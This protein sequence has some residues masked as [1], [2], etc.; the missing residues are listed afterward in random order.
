MVKWLCTVCNI[1]IYDEDRGDPDKGIVPNTRLSELPDS[2]RCPVCGAAIDK[3]IQIHE[4]DNKQKATI[5]IPD[6]K[7]GKKGILIGVDNP[8]ASSESKQEYGKPLGLRGIGQGFSYI[9]NFKALLR[10]RLKTK[11]IAQHMEPVLSTEFFDHKISMP[12]IGAPMSGLSNVNNITEEDFAFGILEGCRLAGTI[13]CTGT[14]HQNHT[15]YIQEYL[16]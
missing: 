6:K 14:L 15:V 2:W 1:Y 12:V 11:L 13:G 5:N 3:F 8:L 4:D 16:P 10:Y 9:A 7:E